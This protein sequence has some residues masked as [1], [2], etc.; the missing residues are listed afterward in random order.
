MAGDPPP[1][2]QEANKTLKTPS[3]LIRIIRDKGEIRERFT[4][5][6]SIC[7]GEDIIKDS[8]KDRKNLCVKT[9]GEGE[10]DIDVNIAENKEPIPSPTSDRKEVTIDVETFKGDVSLRL[11]A[12]SPD[13]RP[14]LRVNVTSG[15]GIV[16]LSIPRSTAGVIET[17]STGPVIVSDKLTQMTNIVTEEGRNRN[18]IVGVVDKWNKE[19]KDQLTVTAK[20]GRVYLRYDDESNEKPE[21]GF[22]TRVFGN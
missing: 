7:I 18:F 15:S 9:K 22:W 4:L 19:Q 14:L 10:I 8:E 21:V 17:T 11:H 6:A 12:S 5:D 3:N 1:Y 2:Y 16:V 13:T 20:Y